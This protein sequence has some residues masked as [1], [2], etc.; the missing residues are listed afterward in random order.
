MKIKILFIIAIVLFSFLSAS[1]WEG[2]AAIAPEGE[3]P[4]KGRYIA[5]N[6]FPVNTVVDI[7]NIETNKSTRVI[8]ASGL[9]SPGLLAIISREAGELIGMRSGS[10]GRIRMIQPSDPIAYL[11]FIEGL[12]SGITD[13]DSGNV[14]TEG[15]FKPYYL[16]NNTQPDNSTGYI[17]EPEWISPVPRKIID[18]PAYTDI[19]EFPYIAFPDDKIPGEIAKAVPENPVIIEEIYPEEIAKAVPEN[20]VITEEIYPEEIARTVPENPVI[21]EETYPEEIAKAVPE[22]PAIIEETLVEVI[23]ITEDIKKKNENKEVEYTLIP[24]EERLPP[25]GVYGIDPAKIIPE[26]VPVKTSPKSNFTVPVITKLDSGWYY[27]QLA[28]FTGPELIES[29]INGI[30][31]NYKP[32]VFNE[33][34]NKYRILLGPLYH[35]E[36]AAVL[37]RFKSIGYK[38]AF[39]RQGK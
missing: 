29:A 37:Q 4:R 5:T 6:S 25:K 2:A 32:V 7:V 28:A 10:I 27:V 14:I 24:A 22:D 20:P 34:E 19:D 35:G 13:Y 1:P 30:D 18:L 11:R 16:D 8:V 36:S 3:L 39:V 9:E 12:S 23:K 17:L 38:D 21:I 26:S 31:K 33:G 15:N